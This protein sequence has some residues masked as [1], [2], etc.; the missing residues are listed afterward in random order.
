MRT[1]EIDNELIL[2]EVPKDAK[3]IAIVSNGIEY[4]TD[5]TYV[6]QYIDFNNRINE[7]IGLIETPNVDF[8]FELKDSWVEKYKPNYNDTDSWM[9]Y[10]DYINDNF[11]SINVDVNDMYEGLTKSFRT[12]IQRKIQ[13]AG[14]YLVNPMSNPFTTKQIGENYQTNTYIAEWQFKERLTIKGNLLLIKKLK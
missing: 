8:D 6:A 13:D 7:I 5:N 3:I 14:F 12:R 1:I 2:V 9:E 10:Y 4:I 11:Y